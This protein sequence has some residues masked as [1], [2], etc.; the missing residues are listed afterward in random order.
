[1][2]QKQVGVIKEKEEKR[3]GEGLKAFQGVKNENK[4][5]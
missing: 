4:K 5:I 3:K 1:M 2:K